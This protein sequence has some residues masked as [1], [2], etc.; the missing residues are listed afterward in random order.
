M[1]NRFFKNINNKYS[2]FLKFIFFLRYLFIIFFLAGV[3][4]LTAPYFFDYKKKEGII[5]NYLLNNY[6]LKVDKLEKIQFHAFPLPHLEVKNLSSNLNSKNIILNSEK[7]SV[8]PNLLSI[9]NYKNFRVKKIIIEKSDLNSNFSNFLFL[10][11]FFLGFK[12][13]ISVKDLNLKLEDGNNNSLVIEKIDYSNYGYKKNFIVGNIFNKK[14]KISL[15]NDLSYIDFKLIDTGVSFIMNL[16]KNQDLNFKGNFKG[17]ILKS[18]LKLD[19]IYDTSSLK[20]NNL[21]YRNKDLSFDSFG[22]IELKPF[23]KINLITELDSIPTKL[24]KNL[25][26][27][28]LLNSKNLISRLNSENKI[29]YKSNKFKRELLDDLKIDFNLAYGRLNILKIFSISQSIFNCQGDVNLLDE[30]PI[31]YFDCSMNSDDKKRL[32]KKFQVQYKNKEEPI[33]LQMKGNLNILNNKVN[34][35][36]IKVNYNYDAAEE[37][38]KFFKETFEKIFF[39][40]NVFNIFNLSKIKKFVLEII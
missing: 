22:S 1:I 13:K 10:N 3:L 30:N 38:L 20:V 17:K 24:L 23:F 35:D 34:F 12:K 5:K 25:D 21:I 14:F 8:Y 15:K 29:I 18:K 36:L 7:L 26:L 28:S 16:Q 6:G 31:Y 32:L 19:F 27:N 33:D 37:D 4:F 11:K 2:R 9:Y 40:E 39:N